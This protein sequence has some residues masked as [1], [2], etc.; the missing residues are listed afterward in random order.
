MCTLSQHEV[1]LIRLALVR[2]AHHER[3][4][5][6]H[7]WG[8]YSAERWQR[9][10][11]AELLAYRLTRGAQEMSKGTDLVRLS[12]NPNANPLV[13]SVKQ[14]VADLIDGVEEHKHLDPR[15]AALAITAF[16]EGAMWAVKL[17]TTEKQ[18]AAPASD[19]PTN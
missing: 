4:Q 12:F 17:V 16:E 19:P 5:C 13:E 14:A 6:R 11:D 1:Q 15:L 18:D 3:K 9:A 8:E 7:V 10:H 2:Y